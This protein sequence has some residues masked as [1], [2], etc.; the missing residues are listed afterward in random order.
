M[1]GQTTVPGDRTVPGEATSTMAGSTTTTMVLP[2]TPT[3]DGGTGGGTLPVTGRGTALL[4]LALG[5]I[6]LGGVL[7]LIRMRMNGSAEA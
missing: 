1:P 6:A 3:P 4:P 5:A 2:T 7:Y